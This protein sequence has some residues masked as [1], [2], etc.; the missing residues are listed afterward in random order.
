M[1]CSVVELRG[2]AA[3]SEDIGVSADARSHV[4]ECLCIGVE[5]GDGCAVAL[6]G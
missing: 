5:G 1:L 2:D 6:E 4:G 3:E